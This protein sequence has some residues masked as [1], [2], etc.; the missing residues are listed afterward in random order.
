MNNPE[1]LFFQYAEMTAPE[2]KGRYPDLDTF[3]REYQPG[4]EE[5]ERMAAWLRAKGQELDDADLEQDWEYLSN[6]VASEIAGQN[7]NREALYLLRLRVDNQVQQALELF[8][9]A[10]LLSGLQ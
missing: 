4:T 8:D 10:G 1:R 5:R 6:R 7:W 2:I 3:V 9:Q